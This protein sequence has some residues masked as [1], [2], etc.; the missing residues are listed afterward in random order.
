MS[1][2]RLLSLVVLS[3][4]TL[5]Q[6][7]AQA[8]GADSAGRRIESVSVRGARTPSVTGGASV[9]VVRVD[10]LPVPLLPAPQL[11][12]ILRQ[13]AFVLVRQNS[14]GEMEIGIRGSDSRQAS[15]MLDGLPLSVGWDSRTDPA[16]I[17]TTGI[18]QVTVVRG[19]STLLAGANTLGGVIRL[20]LN[21]VRGATAPS[22]QLGSGFDQYA[23]R[24]LSATGSVPVKVAGGTLQVRGGVT[25]RQRDGFALP[26]GDP[27]NGISGGTVD[28]GSPDNSALR[29]NSDLA[30][31]DGFGAVRYDHR[32][33]A[34]VSFTATAYDA[35]RGVAPEQHLRSPRFWRYPSQT[36]SLGILSAGTGVH[37]TGLGF[38][39]L[40]VTAGQTTQD[41]EIESYA[42]RTYTT[43]SSRELGKERNGIY[44]VQATHTLPLNAQL[45][46]AGTWSAVSY[47]E[48][49]NAQLTSS[50]ATRF[51]QT[52]QSVGG[53]ID[54][55]LF[56][57]LLLSGGVVQD[58][59][60]TPKTGGRTSLGTLNKTGW[61]VGAT[62][63]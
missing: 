6:A 2:P 47:D 5:S 13:T 16:L 30:Q 48:T 25:N 41:L 56:N 7:A 12:D 42:N 45:R 58:E 29:T 46:L 37:R 63:Q 55:P 36:R 11:A 62:V 4:T 23:S 3:A 15:V 28:S 43:V 59:A 61:R 57:R 10:S 26:G 50:V 38:G 33:G 20:E 49:L 52:L 27:G 14:R 24:V 53:E 21:P 32:S 35:E 39:S 9:V 19:L 60:R 1:L 17:P 22:L 44:R 51:E 8:T 54:V 34:H 40:E 18:Q 31:T